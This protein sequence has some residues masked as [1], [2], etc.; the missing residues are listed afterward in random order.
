MA[1]KSTSAATISACIY[2]NSAGSCSVITSR[3]FNARKSHDL[4]RCRYGWVTAHNTGRFRS[5]ELSHVTEATWR[6]DARLDRFPFPV[7]VGVTLG[8]CRWR[9]VE[10]RVAGVR[11]QWLHCSHHSKHHIIRSSSISI[12]TFFATTCRLHIRSKM[13]LRIE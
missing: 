13:E 12:V 1:K 8:C 4:E 7:V 11:R 3:S 5:V 9:D 10:Q 6:R 2:N